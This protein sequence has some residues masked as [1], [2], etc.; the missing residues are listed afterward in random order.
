MDEIVRKIVERHRDLFGEGVGVERINAGFTNMVFSVGDRYILKVCHDVG[1]EEEF[2]VEIRFYLENGDKPYVPK[3]LV[4]SE[5]KGDVGFH[6]IVMERVNA[7]SLYDVWHTFSEGQR[8][9]VVCQICEIMRDFHKN[10]GEAF[11]WGGYI[12]GRCEEHLTVL[13]RQGQ[14]SVDE[15]LLVKKAME[16]MD[17][18]LESKDFVLIHNDMHFDNLLY[19]SGRLKLIDYESSRYNP[20]DMEL[21]IIFYM[22][23]MPWKHANEEN[24]RFVRIEDYKTLLPYFRKHYPEIFNVPH[25][26]KRIAIYH[27]RDALENY[28]LFT[29]AIELR[30]RIIALAKGIIED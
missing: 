6:Y 1:N 27:L 28:V 16:R 29:D 3:M 11:D 21:E 30:D 4:Y 15:L 26:E 24:E 17:E 13:V 9:D 20:I 5:D 23:E 25:L 10:T 18:Y 22:S 7:P 8:E 19:D 14:L 2:G 12:K